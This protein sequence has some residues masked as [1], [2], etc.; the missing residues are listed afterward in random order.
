MLDRAAPGLIRHLDDEED[1]VI[2][3]MI[4]KGGPAA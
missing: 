4:L 1:I 2:P 3:L